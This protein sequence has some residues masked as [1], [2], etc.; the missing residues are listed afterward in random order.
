MWLFQSIIIIFYIPSLMFSY[1]A[2]YDNPVYETYPKFLYFSTAVLFTIAF[3]PLFTGLGTIFFV[4]SL[5]AY[6]LKN[7]AISFLLDLLGY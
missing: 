1:G 2:S 7:K 6:C 5:P 4:I 3:F